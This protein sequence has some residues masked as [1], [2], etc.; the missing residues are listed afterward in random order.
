M[1]TQ[2]ILKLFGLLILS[3][4]LNTRMGLGQPNVTDKVP[5]EI[6]PVNAP[7]D[8]PNLK[9]PRFPDTTF[10]IRNFG[11]KT[12]K[13][14]NTTTEAIHKAI[15]AAHKAGG[16]KVLIPAGEWWSAPVHLMSNINLHIA[17]DAVLHFSTDKTDYLPV[18]LQ[19]HEG[20]EAY[21]YSPLIYARDVKNIA[22]TGKGTF[23][24]HGKHWWKWA[25]KH[26]DDITPRTKATKTP[27]SRRM[28]GKGAGQEGMRPPFVCF[29]NAKNILIEGIT[30]EKTPFWNILPVY[31]ENIIVR[32]VT[33]RSKDAPNGD[34]VN[35][36]SCKNVL[37]EYNHFETGDDAVVLKSGLNEEALKKDIPTKNVVVRNY[38]AVD[39]Q[40]GSGGIVFG[41][42]T[43]GGIENVYVHDAYFEGNDR[44]IR[45][46]SERGRGNS[47]ENIYIHDIQMKDLDQSAINFNTYYHETAR[48]PA[49]LFKNITIHDI[50]IDGVPVGI[51]MNG[52]P[53]KWLENFTMRDIEIKNAE[54]G[55]RIN[56]VK[57]L[58]LEN[59]KINSEQR[60]MKV[61]DAFEFTIKNVTLNNEVNKNSLLLE[62]KYTGA[63]DIKGYPADNIEL[64]ENISEDIVE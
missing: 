7:F 45:F 1:K 39:V 37:I 17:K 61:H 6:A 22:L 3:F 14:K 9:R 38:K 46:K 11:A 53:E 41:S 48:G 31:S 54:K 19:R 42:E 57:N 2:K 21:N 51:M 60:A 8:M 50:K 13:N 49:P 23:N 20:V 30:L 62:G 56:R 58:S 4:A 47:V 52:L 33:I 55:A 40:T 26:A 34:G 35:P 25:K 5:E 27:L 10:N 63:V 43:S 16:G 28:Y 36:S 32:D 15:A 59:I 64:G 44:G 24:G 18:V 12:G 29:W